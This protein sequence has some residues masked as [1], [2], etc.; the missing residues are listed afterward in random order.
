MSTAANKVMVELTEVLMY[1]GR[2]ELTMFLDL[3]LDTLI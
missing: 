1:G 3:A 2:D